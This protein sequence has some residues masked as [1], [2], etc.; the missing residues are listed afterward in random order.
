MNPR[1]QGGD[2]CR[3]Y[4]P[5]DSRRDMVERSKEATLLQVRHQLANILPQALNLPMLDLGETKH[6]EMYADTVLR[7]DRSH[8]AG[9]D[10]IGQVRQGKS[11]ADLVVVGD[12]DEPHAARFRQPIYGFR[13]VV[14][15]TEKVLEWRDRR[16]AGVKGMN[17][18][19]DLHD[20]LPRPSAGR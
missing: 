16:S 14:A 20:H 6:V 18:G 3:R 8:L 10:H 15:L 7:E 9:D 4:R 5:V 1:Q 13:C 12:G 2:M 11:T 19:I 17:M